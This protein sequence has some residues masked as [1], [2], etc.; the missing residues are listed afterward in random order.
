MRTVGFLSI[1]LLVLHQPTAIIVAQQ[2]SEQG[3]Q[4]DVGAYMDADS[5]QIYAALLQE[6][7]CP[8]YVIRAEIVGTPALT[9]RNLG[10][11]GDRNF[12]R[13]WGVVMEDFAKQ[14][15]TSKLLVHNIPVD[16]QYELLPSSEIFRS[17]R[18]QTGWDD[19]YRRYPSSDGYYWF[20]AVG[21]NSERTRAIVKFNH[22]CGSLCGS[23]EPHFF[24]KKNGKWKEVGV[25]AT[26]PVWVS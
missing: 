9:A 26:I 12:R 23:G 6:H 21:F 24:Q 8:F 13:T 17:E 11:K 18:G 14:N 4:N 15:R 20:S 5:Y 10:I 3:T 2:K 16:T 1:C 22:L 25:N 7:K 19:F